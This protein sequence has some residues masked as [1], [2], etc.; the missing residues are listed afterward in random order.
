MSVDIILNL[1]FRQNLAT[2]FKTIVHFI[3][4]LM[5]SFLGL[6][7]NLLI[8]QNCCGFFQILKAAQCLI[9]ISTSEDKFDRLLV[10]LADFSRILLVFDNVDLNCDSLVERL[11]TVIK[12]VFLDVNAA[13]IIHASAHFLL[14][15]ELVKDL[16][17][18]VVIKQ[19]LI[20]ISLI[21]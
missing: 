6:Q 15:L 14:V 13:Q 19:G 10:L 5:H 8:I 1:E 4:S 2:L 21:K 17:C 16:Q 11:N 7:V 20:I 18:L 12:L 3:L 9:V